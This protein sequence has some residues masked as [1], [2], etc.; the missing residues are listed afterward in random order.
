MITSL[1]LTELTELTSI[2]SNNS[3]YNSYVTK[4]T[5][6]LANIVLLNDLIGLGNRLAEINQSFGNVIFA[7]KAVSPITVGN[8]TVGEV[9]RYTGS[10]LTVYDNNTLIN[11]T[12]T[13]S[14][15]YQYYSEGNLRYAHLSGP[16]IIDGTASKITST[17]YQTTVE[18]WYANSVTNASP[19]TLI[20]SGFSG[21]SIVNN[22][23]TSENAIGCLVNQINDT[24]ELANY[25]LADL[26]QI[27][28]N[29]TDQTIIS[30]LLKIQ[31]DLNNSLTVL[32]D[33]R[34]NVALVSATVSSR[35]FNVDAIHEQFRKS[36]AEL[37][38]MFSGPDLTVVSNVYTSLIKA[39]LFDK[40]QTG[41]KDPLD[42]AAII[43]A[44][45]KAG[46]LDSV[47]DEMKNP[48]NM[49]LPT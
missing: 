30:K 32:I 4:V 37:L 18:S 49:P 34:D 44:L 26:S 39:G 20:F 48:T 28:S 31:Q 25:F 9:L 24:I 42:R 40:I 10:F 7:E 38:G 19:T 45:R 22:Y 46:E 17:M 1:S 6:K 3:S 2:I 33:I 43:N 15:S 14:G 41:I 47:S 8:V 5:D 23:S 11:G 27:I 16:G 35:T 29:I 13:V 12:A 21:N 36:C